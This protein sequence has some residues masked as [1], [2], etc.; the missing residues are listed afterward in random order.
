[1]LVG[2]RD[3]ELHRVGR[4]GERVRYDVEVVRRLP[5]LVLIHGKAVAVADGELLGEGDLKFFVQ[6]TGGESE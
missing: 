4:V 5:P 3:L 1:V 6:E 2:V